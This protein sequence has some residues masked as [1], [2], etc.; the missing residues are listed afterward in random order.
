MTPVLVIAVAASAIALWFWSRWR[1]LAR[2]EYIRGF[3]L[4]PGIFEKLARKRPGLELKDQQLV[5][6][7]LRQFFLA[8]L[9]SGCRFVSMPS[10]VVDDLW[11]ELIL[12]TRHYEQF[13]RRAFGRFLHHTPAV[14]LGADRQNNAGLR[15]VWWYACKEENIN[16][17]DPTRLPLLFAID[18]KLGIAD[19]FIYAPDCRKARDAQSGSTVHCGGDFGSSGFDGSTDGFGDT[20]DGGGSGCGGGCGGD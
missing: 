12:Y 1:R 7:A 16:P 17:R 10:Q 15:R 18:R 5:A 3:R 2:A 20:G 6:R 11:H 9:N 13:C 19:G 14:V 8:Y 4:P